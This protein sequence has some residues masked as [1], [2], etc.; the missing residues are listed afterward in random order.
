M[1]FWNEWNTKWS[2]PNVRPATGV[3]ASQ[4]QSQ[5]YRIDWWCYH[6]DGLRLRLIRYLMSF[7]FSL[8]LLYAQW[9]NKFWP[10]NDTHSISATPLEPTCLYK[11]LY[12]HRE[13]E[14]RARNDYVHTALGTAR[15]RSCTCHHCIRSSNTRQ[16]EGLGSRGPGWYQFFWFVNEH[17]A[18]S[19]DKSA[20]LRRN[21]LNQVSFYQ[22][23]M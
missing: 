9:P 17:V 12:F 19:T 6:A 22:A 21:H 13:C 1:N 4:S 11:L 16:R 10:Y 18:V 8:G 15:D 7:I 20:A 3:R 14:I 5:I 2:L 23:D